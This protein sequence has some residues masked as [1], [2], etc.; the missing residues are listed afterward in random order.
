MRCL[1]LHLLMRWRMGDHLTG[2]WEGLTFYLD[3]M[4]PVAGLPHLNL[5]PYDGLFMSYVSRFEE[6]TERDSHRESYTY[7]GSATGARKATT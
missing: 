5:R 6:L 3:W 1:Y 7:K 2:R 4:N